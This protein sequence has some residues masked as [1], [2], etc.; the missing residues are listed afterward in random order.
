MDDTKAIYRRLMFWCGILESVSLW[1]LFFGMT[2]G[3][4][5]YNTS[6]VVAAAA[7]GGVAASCKWLLT[8]AN[9]YV[10]GKIRSVIIQL[11][12]GIPPF[13]ASDL[14]DCAVPLE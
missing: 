6:D 14:A 1:G 8:I 2:T 7:S 9:R 12:L 5:Y 13:L 11:V 3:I 4:V 10:W